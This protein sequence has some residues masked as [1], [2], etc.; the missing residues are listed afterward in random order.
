MLWHVVSLKGVLQ[1]GQQKA[2]LE[3][4]GYSSLVCLL[5]SW[6]AHVMPSAQA[7]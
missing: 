2:E 4:V 3:I 7:S 5:V 6:S 1:L